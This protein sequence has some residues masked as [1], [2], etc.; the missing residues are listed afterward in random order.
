[1]LNHC[2]KVLN[3]LIVFLS[4]VLLKHIGLYCCLYLKIIMLV[5][6]FIFQ[7]PCSMCCKRD[8]VN[9]HHSVFSLVLNMRQSEIVWETKTKHMWDQDK[10]I[11]NGCL[12]FSKI[13]T[14]DVCYLSFDLRVLASHLKAF[15]TQFTK[16]S[17]KGSMYW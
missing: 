14:S 10:N 13:L 3:K 8:F 9:E 7:L 12:R 1:M 5:K 15:E 4:D 17:V 11:E 2:G 16:G 6:Q